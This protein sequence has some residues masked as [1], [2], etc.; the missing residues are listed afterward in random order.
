MLGQLP[1]EQQKKLKRVIGYSSGTMLLLA[2]LLIFF[3]E[4]IRVETGLDEMTL[5][6]VT[7][8][9]LFLAISD[10]VM[11]KILFKDSDKR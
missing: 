11:V 10:L 5:N 9:L 6:I 1:P 2:A 7:V 3:H 8:L 4:W